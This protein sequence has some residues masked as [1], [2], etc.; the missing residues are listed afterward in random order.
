[1][2]NDEIMKTNTTLIFD[3]QFKWKYVGKCMWILLLQVF[4]NIIFTVFLSIAIPA[5]FSWMSNE[6]IVANDIVIKVL[7]WMVLFFCVALFLE[8]VFITIPAMS[9]GIYRIDTD[10][11]IIKE[12]K[13]GMITADMYIPLSALTDVHYKKYNWFRWLYSPYKIIVIEANG[14]TYDLNCVTHQ[15][16]LFAHLQ[17]AV[18]ENK[19][20]NNI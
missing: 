7:C 5:L 6:K 9:K 10:H 11:L 13:L 8:Y 4:S 20:K 16:E 2:K 12:K 15:D 1:M 19:S 18:E 14:V 17:K 3:N